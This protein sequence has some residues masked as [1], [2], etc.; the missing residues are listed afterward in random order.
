MRTLCKLL[1]LVSLLLILVFP[2][3]YAFGSIEL[4]LVKRVIFVATLVW[5]A[6]AP[7]W[8]GK[9]KPDHNSDF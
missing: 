4:D 3:A 6:T 8:V 5:F 9:N 2:F 7:F 1:G